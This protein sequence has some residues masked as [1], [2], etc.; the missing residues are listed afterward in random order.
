[1]DS[2][3]IVLQHA[4]PSQRGLEFHNEKLPP[5]QGPPT[6]PRGCFIPRCGWS[7]ILEVNSS[8]T[9][10][11]GQAGQN[12]TFMSWYWAKSHLSNMDSGL[13]VLQHAVPSTK[14]SGISQRETASISGS[15]DSA[16]WMFHSTMWMVFHLGS[17][18]LLDEFA[19]QAG[20]N[21]TF[22]S[23]YWAKSHL[24]NM[25][26]GLIVLQ[27][28]VPSTKRSGISQRQTFVGAKGE[29]RNL[30][31]RALHKTGIWES[32]QKNR[33]KAYTDNGRFAPAT[34]KGAWRSAGDFLIASSQENK[35][36]FCLPH[37]QTSGFRVHIPLF[38]SVRIQS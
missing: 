23:W 7:F 6:V 12:W 5:F 14:R 11:A 20:Q 37:F 18:F 29:P 19:G 22:M 2:G 30:L 38:G 15:S 3:L 21:W 32:F 16:T 35:V 24:S 1:M 33:L 26:S 4:V 17:Q 9:E 25:D 31:L 8:S 27:H 36:P 13:I 10:F 34:V 28:A